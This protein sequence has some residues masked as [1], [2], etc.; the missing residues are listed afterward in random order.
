MGQTVSMEDTAEATII[1][2]HEDKVMQEDIEA[3]PWED[4]AGVTMH[5]LDAGVEENTATLMAT[6]RTSAV[7]ARCLSKTTKKPYQL[8]IWLKEISKDAIESWGTMGIIYHIN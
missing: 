8:E 3:K 6:A 5:Q 1:C 7:S 4:A 2:A